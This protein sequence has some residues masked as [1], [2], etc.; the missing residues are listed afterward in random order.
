V[1]TRAVLTAEPDTGRVPD[2]VA[3]PP[4]H[5]RFPLIDGLRAMAAVS[6]LLFHAGGNAPA[7]STTGTSAL[8]GTL[9]I[10][11][12]IF[13]LISGFL[14]YRPF[15]AADVLGA[16]AIRTGPFLWRRALRIIPLYWVATTVVGLATFDSTHR[17][18][19]YFNGEPAWLYYAFGQVYARHGYGGG[20]QQGWTLCIE[21]TFYLALPFYALLALAFRRRV[22]GL[23]AE[24]GLLV[25]L[26]VASQVFRVWI[27][28][29]QD[30]AH[31][32]RTLPAFF[33]LF[34]FGMGLAVVSVYAQLRPAT[35]ATRRVM[36][37]RPELL[38]AAAAVL[39]CLQAWVFRD[40][41]NHRLMDITDGVIATFLLL[42]AVF[43]DGRRTPVRRFLGHPIVAWIGLVSYGM[44]LWHPQVLSAI[45]HTSMGSRIIDVGFVPRAALL[46]ACTSVVAGVT[47]YT[48]ERPVLRL[49]TWSPRRR[50]RSR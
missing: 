29:S 44:Y 18:G 30:T 37:L 1:Q 48:V 34:A 33:Y 38:W 21:V 39:Y 3:P 10:G 13:F 32:V 28:R 46:L 26:G 24:L 16:P 14:L 2:A 49:K 20:L 7:Y 12:P 9:T 40:I 11:V 43:D 35:R 47:Y 5:L 50:G 25:A 15:V 27:G 31:L 45:D 19:G 23:A 17:V 4:G 8:I 6:I 41:G 22:S 42:P 36:A